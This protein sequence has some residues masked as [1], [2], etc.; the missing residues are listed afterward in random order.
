MSINRIM[1]QGRSALAAN[2]VGLTTVSHN[3]ANVN[4]EGFSRQRVEM[5]TNAS[6]GQAGYRI[7]G[8]VNVGSVSR[9]SSDFVNRRLEQSTTQLGEFEGMSEVLSQLQSVIKDDGEQGISRAISRFFNDVRV[10]STQPESQPLRVAVRESANAMA[11]TFKN[12]QGGIDQIK[13]DIDRR[14]EGAITDVN[15]LSKRIADLNTRIMQQEV[16]GASANDERD[17]RD[18]AVKHL[19]KILDLQITPIE[20]GG[21]NISAGRLGVLVNGVDY[22]EFKAVLGEGEAGTGTTTSLRVRQVGYQGALGKDVTDFVEGGSLGGYLTVREKTIPKL[23]K[24]IN[25]TAF[26]LVKQVNNVH[27]EAYGVKGDKGIDFFD[28]MN[29]MSDA[30]SLMSVSSIIKE[31]AANIG[32]AY[33]MK[34]AGDNRALLDLADLQDQKIFNQGSATFTDQAAGI[35]GGVAVQLK[36]VED[37]RETQQGLVEQLN[38]AREKVSGV[39][40]DEEAINLMQYQ[41]AFDASAKMI[42]VADSLMET[43]LNLKRF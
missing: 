14:V 5:V 12:V 40:L 24:D 18:L 23:S 34:A 37:N 30:A 9:A 19:S 42:Q 32:G 7:G 36:A 2:Q 20:N 28:P 1:D 16:G 3:M 10:L 35:I 38:M 4:T 22:S 8:G 26:E 39:S 13:Q 21:I 17:T 11:N 41:R 33:K 31:D 25:S 15:I 27:R 43:V 29:S 6:T